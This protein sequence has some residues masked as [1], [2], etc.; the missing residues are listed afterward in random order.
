MTNSL[1][2]A[3]LGL[4]DL[5][6]VGKNA[7]LGETVGHL[8]DAGVRVPDGFATTAEAYRLFLDETGLAD[9]I[10]GR[11]AGLATDDV[12]TLTEVGR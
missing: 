9:T 3:D 8:A 11:L 6:R 4:T 12:E 10:A 1:Q 7:S 5:D 2:L